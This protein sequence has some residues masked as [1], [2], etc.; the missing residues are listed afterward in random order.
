M[1]N[2]SMSIAV[3]TIVVHISFY[4]DRYQKSV[5]CSVGCVV[6][7]KDSAGLCHRWS[8][9]LGPTLSFHYVE[10]LGALLFRLQRC[11]SEVLLKLDVRRFSHIV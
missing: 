5:K 3:R 2:S 10:D 6:H 11:D 4:C 8:A 1:H 7:S 9:S